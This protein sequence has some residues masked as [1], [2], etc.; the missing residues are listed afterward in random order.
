MYK[1]GGLVA[2]QWTQF[3][4]GLK[5]RPKFHGPYE[6]TKVKSHDRYD[7]KKVGNHKGP[8]N[9]STAADHMKPLT[10]D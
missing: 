7:V 8:I 6:V 10:K 3:G 9:T 5:M 1:R 2:I 4:S